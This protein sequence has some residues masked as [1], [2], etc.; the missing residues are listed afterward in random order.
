MN[1]TNLPQNTS[2]DTTENVKQFFDRYYQTP[3]TFPSNQIDAVVGFFQRRGFDIE[4]S[5]STAITLLTQAKNE[6]INVFQLLDT[7][8]SLTDVQLSQL[9]AQVLNA[10]REKT[11]LLGYRVAPVANPYESRNILV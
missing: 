8:K 2:V 7:M 1:T 3:I 6:G 11:S 5:R 4:S 9:V 10:S